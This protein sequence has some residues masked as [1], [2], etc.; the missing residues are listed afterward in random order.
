MDL[1]EFGFSERE[2]KVYLALLQLGSTTV[3]PIA[4]ETKI[5][6]AKIY[7][8]LEKLITKGYATY[9]LKSKTKY[10]QALS[11]KKVLTDHKE[12]EQKLKLLI[13]KLEQLEQFSQSPQLA[14]VYE[15][16]EAIKSLFS[17][18]L[19]EKPKFY[20]AFAFQ[21]EY[22]QSEQAVR[23]LRNVHQ[24]LAEEKVE[25]KA[26]A[27]KSIRKQFIKS[28]G[29]IVGMEYRFTNLAIPFGLII[30]ENRIINWIWGERPTAIVIESEQIA[31]LYKTFFNEQWD[32]TK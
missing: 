21:N 19:T 24:R 11:P 18:M 5:Q 10:F 22:L 7:Q 23:F 30:C 16:Y 20:Y 27:H 12:K 14:K 31:K 4:S 15:G 3:G 17:Q 1:K 25:D 9:I 6:H 28:Y 32:L 2:E 8:T 29:D 13:P 26:I